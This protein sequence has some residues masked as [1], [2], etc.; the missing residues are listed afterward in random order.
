[1][2]AGLLAFHIAGAFPVSV[3]KTVAIDGQQQKVDYSC[4]DSS[5]VMPLW[6]APVFPFNLLMISSAEEPTFLHKLKERRVNCKV[7]IL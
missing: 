6:H 7:L 3:T 2:T 5:G 4:G 1:M